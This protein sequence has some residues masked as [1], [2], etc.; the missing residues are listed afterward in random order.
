MPEKDDALKLYDE[1][2]ERGKTFVDN[3]VA[4]VE[5]ARK[6]KYGGSI[7]FGPQSAR[8]LVIR[9]LARYWSGRIPEGWEL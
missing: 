7:P 4:S 6:R 9:F 2:N 5:E 8:I 3:L 1:L